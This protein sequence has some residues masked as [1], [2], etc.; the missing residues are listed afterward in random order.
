VRA[1]WRAYPALNIRIFTQPGPVGDI[2]AAMEYR[3]G[4]LPGNP[5]QRRVLSSSNG[6]RDGE[7]ARNER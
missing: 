7:S 6:G 2:K 1:N 3:G 5:A 4:H